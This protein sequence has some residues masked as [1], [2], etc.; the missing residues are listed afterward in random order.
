MKRAPNRDKH[1]PVALRIPSL[2]FMHLKL[3]TLGAA[4]GCCDEP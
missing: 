3:K 1:V 2:T 4:N